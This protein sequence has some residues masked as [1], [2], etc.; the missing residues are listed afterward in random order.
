LGRFRRER[1]PEIRM[2][3]YERRGLERFEIESM[4]VKG[5]LNGKRE[6]RG[7]CY[8]RFALRKGLL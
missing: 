1:D 6:D 8:T 4:V 2:R 3:R 7:R 5:R